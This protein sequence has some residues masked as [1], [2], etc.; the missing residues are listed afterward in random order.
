MD[1]LRRAVEQLS[2]PICAKCGV[3]MAWLRSSLLKEE[4]AIAHLFT[5][6]NCNSVREEKTPL[7][8]QGE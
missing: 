3:E 1:V 8:P 6:A 7:K 5:C 4:H 2:A